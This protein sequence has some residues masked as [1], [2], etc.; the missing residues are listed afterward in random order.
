[1][2]AISTFYFLCL[3]IVTQSRRNF[4]FVSLSKTCE[5]LWP[6]NYCGA[7]INDARTWP[8]VVYSSPM[9]IKFGL[10]ATML[11]FLVFT[12]TRHSCPPASHL[13]WS[14][15]VVFDDEGIFDNCLPTRNL[16][17]HILL[18]DLKFH[19]DRLSFV[20]SRDS[21]DFQFLS[22]PQRRSFDFEQNF[23]VD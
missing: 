6:F 9:I 21:F 8:N 17:L 14:F 20:V 7:I 12:I 11:L 3:F 16:P 23:L 1:M 18:H 15:F 4:K 13:R 22:H 10:L 2:R 5:N 19:W